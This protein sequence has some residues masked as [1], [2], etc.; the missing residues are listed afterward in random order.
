MWYRHMPEVAFDLIK[1]APDKARTSRHRAKNKD[2]HL[3]GCVRVFF[4]LLPSCHQPFNSASGEH[5]R[6]PAHKLNSPSTTWQLSH[7]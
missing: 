7:R 6:P 1:L 4:Y 2:Y 3:A 5:V